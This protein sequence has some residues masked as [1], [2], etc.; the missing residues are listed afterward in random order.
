MK[1]SMEPIVLGAVAGT[2]T[3][4]LDVLTAETPGIDSCDGRFVDA[5]GLDPASPFDS[6]GTLSE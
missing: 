5:K 6:D 3:L 2:P 1:S 4:E